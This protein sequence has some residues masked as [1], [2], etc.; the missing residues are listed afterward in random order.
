MATK[1][2]FKKDFR[3][4]IREPQKSKKEEN[5]EKIITYVPDMKVSD[6]ASALD[7]TNATLIKKL[8]S[9]GMITSINQVLDR[10]TIEL[11]ALDFGYEV[12]DEVITDL[13]RYDEI[14][15]VD[16][17]KDLVKRSPI[18]TI[19]G[20]VDHGKTTLL[21]AIRHTRVVQGEAGGITQHIGAYQVDWNGE[22]ITF[23]DTP[24]HAAFTE[25]RARG[26]K[27]T[28]IVILVVAADDGVKPQTIEALEHAKAAKVPIIVAVNKV[29]K[30]NANPD[31]IMSTLSSYDL[32]PETWGGKTPYVMI[33][34]L[35][36]QGID[37]LLDV[38]QLVAEMEEL[39]A[40]PNRPARGTVIEASLD[41]G[42]GPVA[43]I[44]VETGTLHVGDIVVI[45]NTYG[46][47]RTMNDDL[48]RRFTEALP[49][50]PVEITGLEDVPQAGDIFM[51]FQDEKLA[52]QT[53]EARASKVRETLAKSMKATSLESMFGD[54]EVGEKV[55]NVILKADVQGSVEVIKNM[56]EKIDIEGF[57]ASVVRAGV[58]AIT[59]SDVTLASASGAIIIG[60][61]VRPAAN[62]K[63]LANENGIEIRLYNVIYRITED[64]EKALKG[65]LEPTYE[66]VVT[67]QAQVRQVFK[68]S[69]V[70]TVAGCYVT[71]GYISRNSKVT[72][73]RD[74]IVIYKGELS[75]LKR[76]KDEVK[77]VKQGFECGISI[78]NY[79]DIKEGDVIEAS[80][81]KEVEVA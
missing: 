80:I 57:H 53:A 8:M 58:G 12:K 55:L 64:I 41:R 68:I 67:G 34:A 51:V 15:I 61:N 70:G 37:E 18:I 13:T 66:E 31:L 75:S 4:D 30:P 23:I 33:S 11:I 48:K 40:N 9:L 3:K 56:L 76:F 62:V 16:D 63:E 10:E 19:M 47:I 46:R 52:R 50:T 38:I 59:E 69:K 20:H 28:D 22:K 17:P 1:K 27:V 6:V 81:D 21:D 42:R 60:F 72:L 36:R 7:V 65:M 24:G 45:G 77:E 14:E 26:A 71:E 79:N 25:M 5:K 32:T 44:I 78:V 49:G 54:K 39:K 2:P 35:K 74:G 73:I 43:T 29:D